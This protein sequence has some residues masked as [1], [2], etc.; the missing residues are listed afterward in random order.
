MRERYKERYRGRVFYRKRKLEEEEKV[1]ETVLLK[2]KME[3]LA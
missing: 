1:P 3:M 2:K